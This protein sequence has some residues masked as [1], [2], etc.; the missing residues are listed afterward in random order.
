MPPGGGMGG[1]DFRTHQ[2][3]HTVLGKMLIFTLRLDRS[4]KTTQSAADDRVH[5]FFFFAKMLSV[6]SL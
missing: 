4:A 1:M 5:R 3:Q 6:L 2:N